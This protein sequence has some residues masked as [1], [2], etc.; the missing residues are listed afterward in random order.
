MNPPSAKVQQQSGAW[1]GLRRSTNFTCKF[2]SAAAIVGERGTCCEQKR[3]DVCVWY[4]PRE[5]GKRKYEH[6]LCLFGGQITK[7]TKK[8]TRL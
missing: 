8:T 6:E 5:E 4:T 1:M 7:G 2:E 3:D